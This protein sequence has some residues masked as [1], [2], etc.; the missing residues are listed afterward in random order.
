M[1][2]YLPQSK[3]HAKAGIA[4]SSSISLI[5]P[6][7]IGIRDTDYGGYLGRKNTLERNF[8]NSLTG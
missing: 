8:E 5:S 3:L 2:W 1:R 7:D 4:Q 6:L